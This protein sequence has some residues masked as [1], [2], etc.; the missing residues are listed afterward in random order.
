MKNV[1]YCKN[2][3]KWIFI[4]KEKQSISRKGMYIVHVNTLSEVEDRKYGHYVHLQD[5]PLGTVSTMYN[6]CPEMHLIRHKPNF[7]IQQEVSL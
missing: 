5:P 6:V 4:R 1:L 2:S 7:V 3:G